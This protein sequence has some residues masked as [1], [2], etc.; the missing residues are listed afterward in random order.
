M[1][2]APANQRRALG[3]AEGGSLIGMGTGRDLQGQGG[4]GLQ[5]SQHR[6]RTCLEPY[7]ILAIALVVCS[8]PT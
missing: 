7:H 6:L 2:S 5:P 1:R 3:R 8:P 4:Q